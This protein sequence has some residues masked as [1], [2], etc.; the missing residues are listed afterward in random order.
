MR[1]TNKIFVILDHFLPFQ[2]PKNPKNEIFQ[3]MKNTPEDMIILPKI[4]LICYTVPEIRCMTDVILIFYFGLIFALLRC[5]QPK[6]SK[7]K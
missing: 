1:A 4:M 7:S 5:Q 2:A 3:K 6:K